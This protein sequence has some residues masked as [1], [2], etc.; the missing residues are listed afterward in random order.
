[1]YAFQ[2]ILFF[3]LKWLRDDVSVYEFMPI[4]P[5]K[6]T[7]TSRIFLGYIIIIITEHSKII[8]RVWSEYN[9]TFK[10]PLIPMKL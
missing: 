10:K 4:I 7:Q 1:M 6:N 3:K 9:V 2:N 5:M 8:L